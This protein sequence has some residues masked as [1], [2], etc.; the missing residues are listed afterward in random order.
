MPLWCFLPFCTSP[1]VAQTPD[2]RNYHAD[3]LLNLGIRQ[4]KTGQFPA[5]IESLQKALAL[6]QSLGDAKG[7]ANCLSSLGDTY[8]SLGRYSET[9]IFYQQ[10]LEIRQGIGDR[11]GELESLLGLSN[12]YL[13]L[14][15]EQDAK[16]L[17][18]QAEALR[19]EIGNPKRQAA[20]L[21]NLALD[22]RSQGQYQQAIAF[23]QQ[24]LKLAREIGDRKLEAESL[25][26][27]AQAYELS[28]QPQK[29]I[30]LY[31]QQ[32]E[33]AQ[34]SK[35][36][37]Q[38]ASALNQ[39]A[40]VHNSQGQLPQAIELYQQ[41]LEIARKSKNA[42]REASALNQLAT[43]YESQGQYEKAIELYQQQ[44]DTAKKSS[45]SLAE[46]TALNKLALAFLKSNNPTEAQP[47]LI[48]ALKV[49]DAI[50]A[51]LGSNDNYFAEQATTHRLL[52][53]TLI[54]QK[55]PEAALEMAE[56]G[57]MKAIVQLLGLRFTSEPVGTG[58]KAAPP[59][60]T[61]P[62]IVAIKQIAKAQ[63]ATIVEYSIISERELY[64]WVIQPTGEI[65]FRSID[66]NPPKAV[67]PISS[68]KEVVG[69]SLESIGV[70]NKN[71]KNAAA[72]PEKNQSLLQL[73]QVLIKPIKDLLPKDAKA[74]VIFIPD[75]EL[76]F[77]PFPALVDIRGKHLIE[78]HTILTSPA[79]QI[80]ALTKQQRQRVSGDK[81]LVF[82]NPTMPNVT[83]AI[84]Q[85]PQSLPPLLRGEQEALE[86]AEL[87]KTQPLIGN[88]A[89]KS[90]FLQQLP[91]AR[92][93]HLATYGLLDEV[94][95]QGVPG[96]IAF[97]P[98]GNDD[99]I[100]TAAEILNL[101]QPLK[102][103]PLKAELVVLSAGNTGRGNLAGD[104]LISLST[105]L[106]SAGVPSII[107]SLGSASDASTTDL[108]V[109]F[110]RQLKQTG[111]KAQ[112][113]RQA[114]LSTVKKYPNSKQW[115][116]FTLIG[117]AQ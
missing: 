86:I 5:A 20:F 114:M 67:Y 79:I 72:S 11:A 40:T 58:L 97:A 59:S 106:I 57:R 116:A 16:T 31:Q 19:R 51:K 69:N 94:K 90:A 6:Y 24:Q 3:L 102:P 4:H 27:L 78:K 64:A 70:K 52:Q 91:K 36:P 32:L 35:N 105:S 92:R 30:E 13:Y 99:G 10:S 25:E 22:S 47:K 89:T 50:R 62:N 104:G 73:Y 12:A 2:A 43:A 66:I 76:Y 42:E 84:A 110:Y 9:A 113:L 39:I 53:Q 117:E 95:R 18:Q 109:E 37:E 96:G 115:A 7:V 17:K 87:L 83:V 56:Q 1:V 101:Y 46:G 93:I 80:L 21:N 65:V 100:L 75:K 63:K 41:Q 85:P 61:L 48:E 33:I 111:D 60:M 34:K 45:N 82:G 26:K 77:V 54:A 88:Q 98:S 29:A 108:M 23:H 112:A 38:E 107:L 44:L 81:V 15:Q 8:F 103:S 14:G 74:R 49:W 68:L 55:Q 71:S 28:G